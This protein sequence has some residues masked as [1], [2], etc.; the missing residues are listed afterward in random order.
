MFFTALALVVVHSILS[1]M[2]GH[3]VHLS[4]RM[5]IFVLCRSANRV[6]KDMAIAIVF[7]SLPLPDSLVHCCSHRRSKTTGIYSKLNFR[8][9]FKTRPIFFTYTN[10]ISQIVV[11]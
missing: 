9:N 7:L 11:D 4:S 10:F 8:I 5:R 2:C 1:N 3:K 6:I